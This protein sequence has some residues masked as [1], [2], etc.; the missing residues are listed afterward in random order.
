M[1]LKGEDLSSEIIEKAE[2]ALNR[3]RARK[4]LKWLQPV[5]I[6]A[7]AFLRS[8]PK[9]LRAEPDQIEICDRR[10]VSKL[11]GKVFGTGQTERGGRE[12]LPSELRTLKESEANAIKTDPELL[13]LIAKREE[14]RKELKEYTQKIQL[15]RSQV[16]RK[17]KKDVGW[18]PDE[19]LFHSPVFR[20]STMGEIRKLGN[21][22]L[23]KIFGKLAGFHRTNDRVKRMRL[24]MELEEVTYTV[25]T[26]TDPETGKSAR[27]SMDDVGPPDSMLTWESLATILKLHI[28]YVIP[29]NRIASM[30]GHDYFSSA[31]QTRWLRDT[32]WI[33]APIYIELFYQLANSRYWQGDDTTTKVLNIAPSEKEDALHKVIEE[34]LPFGFNLKGKEG[35]KSKLNVSF[36]TGKTGIGPETTIRFYRTHLGSFGDLTSELLARR[37]PK[38]PDVIIQ[39]DMS[40][41]NLPHIRYTDLFKIKMAGCGAHA[42]RGF[43]DERKHIDACYFFLR[44]F[45]ELSSIEEDYGEFRFEDAKAMRKRTKYSRWI[46]GL[47][48][49]GAL[50]VINQRRESPGILISYEP[51]YWPK[52]SGFLKACQY[53]INH[54]DE[55]TLYLTHP[56]LDWTNNLSERAQRKEKLMLNSSFFRK[57]REGRVTLDIL[58]TI[59][60]TAQVAKVNLQDYL[61]YV[62]L[63]KEDAKAHPHL[64]TPLA[65]AQKAAQRVSSPQQE[66]VL[67]AAN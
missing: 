53:I 41:T 29:M 5:F 13:G 57:S 11:K 32:A 39:G 10:Y 35:K 66:V 15:K 20:R 19:S 18:R 33:F 12:R 63:N 34:E 46:W 64:Y 22:M 59:L 31:N 54:F 60:A 1:K 21:E 44:C 50:T 6:V 14:L 51:V 55:L 28:E 27:A 38:F 37:S 62:I 49:K 45:A 3:G 30:I 9:K 24:K 4:S 17:V 8:L 16:R 26:V 65:F 58:K 47:I 48:R 56:E 25:E 40:T 52:D 67:Q 7:D 42:R 36:V 23:K 61:Q 43:W 2:E